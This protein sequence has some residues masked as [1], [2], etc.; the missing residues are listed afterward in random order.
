MSGDVIRF[1]LS[2]SSPPQGRIYVYY[3]NFEPVKNVSTAEINVPMFT[4]FS[5][6]STSDSL[7]CLYKKLNPN[8][9]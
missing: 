2:P 4:L 7:R 9:T 3:T 1:P 6:N 5:K 8:E